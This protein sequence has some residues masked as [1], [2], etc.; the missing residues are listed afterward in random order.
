MDEEGEA[1]PCTD[2]CTAVSTSKH[3][4]SFHLAEGNENKGDDSQETGNTFSVWL[5]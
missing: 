1:A 5:K 3:T 2:Q 4:S